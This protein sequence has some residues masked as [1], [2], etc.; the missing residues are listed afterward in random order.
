MQELKR[1]LVCVDLT[2]MDKSVI[3]YASL[4]A[5]IM[6]SI[7]VD[8]LHISD[9]DIDSKKAKIEQEVQESFTAKAETTVNIESGNVVDTTISW[10]GLHRMELI[11]LGKKKKSLSSAKN[12]MAIT[13]KALCSVLLVPAMEDYA[14]KKLLV[15]ID[16]SIGSKMSIKQAL[17]IKGKSDAQI[18]LQHVFYVHTGY[19][20]SGKTY[21]E[22]GAILHKNAEKEYKMFLREHGF[23]ASQFEII[24][25]LDDD[26]K[27][28]DNIYETAKE[29]G[30]DLIFLGARGRT[31]AAAFIKGSTALDL[32]KYDDDVPFFI[33]KDEGERMGFWE[34]LMKI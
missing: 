31:P 23:D 17:T 7:K 30:A 14:F 11:I 27:P 33:V 9:S 34:A 24:F 28:F 20:T 10:A 19:S 22:F 3:K 12:A 25:T 8:F 21:E 1:I 18:I 15:P 29:N 13:N 16:F 26:S 5:E 4:L 32:I 2:E 6:E